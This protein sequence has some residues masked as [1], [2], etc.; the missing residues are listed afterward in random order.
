MS[1]AS[2]HVSAA[3]HVSKASIVE[4]ANKLAIRENGR[5]SGSVLTSEFFIILD[6]SRMGGFVL[7]LARNS[8]NRKERCLNDFS[9]GKQVLIEF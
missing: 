8:K 3:E 5:A 6:L 1:S 2:E 7:E 9:I 4:Q